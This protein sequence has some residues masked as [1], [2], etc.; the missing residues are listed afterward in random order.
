M[1]PAA[2]LDLHTIAQY[3]QKTIVN[4][5]KQKVPEHGGLKVIKY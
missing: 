2:K 1:V 4:Y 3:K 5:M